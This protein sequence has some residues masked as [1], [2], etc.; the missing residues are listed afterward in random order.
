MKAKYDPLRPSPTLLIKLGSALIHAEEM[1]E[2]KMKNAEFDIPAFKTVADD[3][4]VK[5]WVKE[6]GA[7]L[8]LKRSTRA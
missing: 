8:P 5:T 6:M 4:E 2:T 3:P 1:I 7:M